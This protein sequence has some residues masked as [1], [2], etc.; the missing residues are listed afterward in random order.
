[1]L[2][3]SERFGRPTIWAACG[4][5]AM[6]KRAGTRASVGNPY[7]EDNVVPP[8]SHALHLAVRRESRE[9]TAIQRRR[10]LK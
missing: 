8:H 1:M 4:V 6:V 2:L 5:I 9:L 3:E 10:E 7:L